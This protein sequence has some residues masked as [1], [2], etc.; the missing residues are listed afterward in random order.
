MDQ[1]FELKISTDIRE[2]PKISALLD[3]RMHTYG[4]DSEEILDTQLAVEESVTNV[5]NHGYKKPG[6]EIIVSC[7]ISPD[8]IEVQITD[9][10]PRFDPLAVPEPEL[11]SSIEEREIGGL[12]VFLIRKVMDETSYRYESGKNILVLIKRSS[13][14]PEKLVAF[15]EKAYEYAHVHGQEAALFEFN[16]QTGRFVKG[17]LY[18]FAYDT[19]GNTL[20]HPFQPDLLGKNRLDTT[21]AHGTT[22]IRDL[23]ST[24]QCGG[25]FARYLYMDPSDNYNVKPKLSYAMMV[26]QGWFIGAGIY[27][28]HEE[29]PIVQMGADQQVR[30]NLTSFV[31]EAITYAGKNGKDAAIREFNN[32]N[33]SFV[34]GNLYI[35]AFDFNGTTLALP[36]QPWLI[37]TDL[38]GLQD[39]FGVNYTKIEIYLAQHGGGFIFYH[40]P[41]PAHN[42][43]LEPKVSYVHKVDETWWLGAGVYLS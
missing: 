27:E 39:P 40:Y 8:R 37:G 15:V 36:H 6:G 23:I 14:S 38:S 19:T 29:G 16:N 4:F 41:N 1:S 35:Y 5:I 31:E 43:T 10:A 30:K 26:D 25:G 7:R 28:A 21:D 12:G 22:F 32:R 34:R 42:M 11:D 18:I 33:G 24:A 3:E 13:I 2:I 17:E 20:A 9:A